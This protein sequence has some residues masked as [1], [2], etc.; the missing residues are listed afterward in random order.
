[1]NKYVTHIYFFLVW[2]KKMM[3]NDNKT[4]SIVLQSPYFSKR[5]EVIALLRI[6][7]YNVGKFMRKHKIFVKVEHIGTMLKTKQKSCQSCNFWKKPRHDTLIKILRYNSFPLC[8]IPMGD[9][10]SKVQEKRS[11]S[12]SGFF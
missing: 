8:L 6:F 9:S 5:C 4:N 3:I 1:M 11:T 12:K 7:F 10:M 2:Y